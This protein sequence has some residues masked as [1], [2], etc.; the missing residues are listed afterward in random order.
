MFFGNIFFRHST[1]YLL[2]D[3]STEL[4][5]FQ[6]F[7]LNFLVNISSLLVIITHNSEV[8]M[9]SSCVLI[10]LF[11]FG[12]ITKIFRTILL[13]STGST[14]TI[15]CRSIDGDAQLRN[16]LLTSSMAIS[17]Q[18]VGQIVKLLCFVSF[19][20][21]RGNKYCHNLWFTCHHLNTLKF[22]VRIWFEASSEVENRK[23]FVEFSKSM[24]CTIWL[25]I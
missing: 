6:L 13:W 2:A 8:I 4:V 25:Q 1:S 17:G 24:F 20:I 15:F 3:L 9:L 12:W 18:H 23:R 14:Q 5:R 19:I 11:V 16:I 7:L 21:H 10:S 22:Q